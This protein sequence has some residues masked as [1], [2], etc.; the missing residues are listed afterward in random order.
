MGLRGVSREA[1][2]RKNPIAA[3]TYGLGGLHG[4]REG[5][6]DKKKRAITKPLP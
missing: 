4:D 1:L 3:C 6:D 2:V 5:G